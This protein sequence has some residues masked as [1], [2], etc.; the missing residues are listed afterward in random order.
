MDVSE[1][2]LFRNSAI[3][4]LNII[5]E[6]CSHLILSQLGSAGLPFG[7]YEK[8]HSRVHTQTQKLQPDTQKCCFQPLQPQLFLNTKQIKLPE[9][10]NEINYN[11]S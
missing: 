6:K 8:F 2:G 11:L 1:G 3:R 5:Q 10:P 9:V 7:L 4:N